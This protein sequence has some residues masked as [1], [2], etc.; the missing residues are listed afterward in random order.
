M[1]HIQYLVNNKMFK[2]ALERAEQ[3]IYRAALSYTGYNESATAKLLG[4]ARGTL[5]TKLK[6]WRETD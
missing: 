4:V 2:Q 6:R 1:K 5:R 3:E